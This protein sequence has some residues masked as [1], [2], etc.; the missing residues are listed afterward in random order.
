M[1][2][3]PY[4]QSALSSLRGAIGTG[5]KRVILVLPTGAGKTHIAKAV[6]EGA[7]A[8]GK[9]VLFL[10]PRRELIY[11]VSDKLKSAGVWHGLI[12]AGEPTHRGCAVQVASFDTLHARG[13]RTNRIHMPQADVL[14]VDEAHLS[15]ADTRKAIIQSY[16]DAIVIGLTATPARAD[17]RGL[18]EIYED[19]VEG[20]NIRTLT[21]DG[22]L[23]PVRYFAPS[24]PDLAGVKLNRDG[25]YV[26][27]QLSGRMN[28]PQLVGDIVSNWLRLAN[29]RSTVV[30]CVDRKHSRHVC[31]E[32]LAHGVKAE[33][34][35]GETPQ[36][37][38]ADILRRVDSGEITVLCNVFVATYGL[39]IPRLSVAVLARP[40]RSIALYLQT[41]GRV[42]RPFEGKS[43]ALIIDHAGAVKDHGFVDSF[44]PW[45]LDADTTVRERKEAAQREKGEAKE[46]TC[47]NC[48]TV[49]KAR[50]SCPTCGMQIV[51]ESRAI[52]TH[53]ADLQEIKAAAK[54]DNREAT[55]EEKRA[56][57]GQ[58]RAYARAHGYEEGWVAHRYRTRFD[59]WP[60]DPRVRDAPPVEYGDEVKRWVTH[61]QIKYAK[62]RVA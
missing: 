52:P 21:E 6:I 5:A 10:A 59:C 3:R 56:F 58:L 40:T 39:D 25:D 38:R 15:I 7:V 50:R 37:E 35:D 17:G 20:A 11:Q 43:D 53:E 54:K 42:L 22:F 29:G 48:A 45:S 30:F 4:Q 46:I 23:V 31:D 27:K 28:Q 33:H 18:G 49:F 19:L 61:Q 24:E 12:M 51:P 57:I 32:F 36:N 41:C 26:E 34:L 55:W 60:N 47:H 8:K 9:R 16:P 62:R 13:M 44:V 1:S 14:I 2:L